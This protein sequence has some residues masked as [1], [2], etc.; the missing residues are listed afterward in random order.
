MFLFLYVE[1]FKEQVLEKFII[2]LLHIN[3]KSYGEFYL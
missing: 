2:S 3:Y 1:S